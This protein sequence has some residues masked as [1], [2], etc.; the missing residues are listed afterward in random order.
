MSNEICLKQIAQ[1]CIEQPER[2][3][4]DTEPMFHE[5][6]KY[7]EVPMGSEELNIR[8]VEKMHNKPVHK[9]KITR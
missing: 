6:T 2:A 1:R 5:V 9:D 3:V 4:F 7:F 8:I